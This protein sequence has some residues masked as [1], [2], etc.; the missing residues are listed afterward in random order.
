MARDKTLFKWMQSLSVDTLS[1]DSINRYLEEEIVHDKADILNQ[2]GQTLNSMSTGERK[3]TFLTYHL[4]RPAE[5]LVLDHFF[6]GIDVQSH[7]SIRE[8]LN[9]AVKNIHAIN[10]Y[11]RNEDHL[12]F[13]KK[14][15]LFEKGMLIPSTFQ[16]I[17]AVRAIHFDGSIPD[18]AREPKYYDE[19]LVCF[20]KVSISYLNKPVLKDISWQIRMGEFWHLYGPNGA[21]KTTLLTLISG[22]NTK[23]YGQD[24]TLFGQRKGSGESIWEIRQKVG[25]FTSNMIF[26]FKKRQTVREIIISGFYDSVGL[27][28]VPGEVEILLADEWLVFLG[29]S[30]HAN[31]PFIATSLCHQRMILIARAM[32]KHPPLLILDEPTVD[33]DEQSVQLMVALVNRIA[34][35]RQTTLIYVSHRMDA[36]LNLTHTYELVSNENGSSGISRKISS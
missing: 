32:V 10:I 31:E 34:S 36:G 8:K 12:T 4:S 16:Q 26:Q 22:D 3:R 5:V 17:K 7:D 19:T 20:N 24:I 33:L 9:K 29:L 30:E 27:Y 25:Y 15:Y 35:T 14:N 6:D 2:F 21:G 18:P 28:V 23:A 11:S 13:A 1:P